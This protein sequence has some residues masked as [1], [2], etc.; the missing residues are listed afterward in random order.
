[1][2][3]TLQVSLNCLPITVTVI[4]NFRSDTDPLIF[5]VAL[6]MAFYS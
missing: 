4:V 5:S 6:E 3:N 2:S 1:M